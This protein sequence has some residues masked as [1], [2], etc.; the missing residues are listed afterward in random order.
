MSEAAPVEAP[1]VGLRRRLAERLFGFDYFIS[2]RRTSSTRYAKALRAAL[3]DR[4]LSAFLDAAGDGFVPGMPLARETARAVR[5]STAMVL[6]VQSDTFESEYIIDEIR[7]FHRAGKLLV[8]IDLDGT[9]A[10]LRNDPEARQEVT[11]DEETRGLLEATC[12]SPIAI[13]EEDRAQEPSQD[14]VDKLAGGLGTLTRAVLR[15]RF[16]LATALLVVLLASAAM[17]GWTQERA[18]RKQ[19]LRRLAEVEWRAAILAREDTD[20]I[21]A[22]HHFLASATASAEAG[23]DDRVSDAQLAASLEL[24]AFDRAWVHGGV[25]DG[26]AFAPEAKRFVAWSREG[27]LR[28]WSTEQAQPLWSAAESTPIDDVLWLAQ[29]RHFLSHSGHGIVARWAPAESNQPTWRYEHDNPIDGFGYHQDTG[30]AL[31]WSGDGYVFLLN[32]TSGESLQTWRHGSSVISG[33]FDSSGSR[34][35]TASSDETVCMWSTA[36]TEPKWCQTFDSGARGAV[37]SPDESSVLSWTIAGAVHLL[38]ATDGASAWQRR[39]NDAVIG[40]RFVD[41]ETVLTWS[42]DGICT[43]RAVRDGEEI[44]QLEQPGNLDGCDL[45]PSKDRALTWAGWAGDRTARLWTR[46]SST[47]SAW[48]AVTFSHESDVHDAWI[49]ASGDVLSRTAEGQLLIWSAGEIEPTWMQHHRGLGGVAPDPSGGVL[50]WGDNGIIRRWTPERSAPTS[51]PVA[52]GRAELSTDGSSV[53]SATSDAVVRYRVADAEILDRF[54]HRCGLLGWRLLPTGNVLSWCD[55]GQLFVWISSQEEPRRLDGEDDLLAVTLLAE[56]RT[57]LAW[58]E[59]GEHRLWSLVDGESIA[60]LTHWRADEV[61]YDEMTGR[62]I[63][64]GGHDQTARVW[65]ASSGTPLAAYEHDNWIQWAAFGDNDTLVTL[66][67]LEVRLIPAE[68]CDGCEVVDRRL[69]HD[70]ELEGAELSADGRRVITWTDKEVLLWDVGSGQLLHENGYEDEDP[71]GLRGAV[72]NADGSM[73][74]SWT[75][76]GLRSWTP[77]RPHEISD[78]PASGTAAVRFDR[79]ADRFW[80]WSHSGVIRLWS[81]GRTEHLLELAGTDSVGALELSPEG[82]ALLAWDH[83]TAPRW[84]SI[85][86]SQELDPHREMVALAAR[87]GVGFG[88][89]GR[90]ET[91]PFT[92]WLE[93]VAR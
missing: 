4:R 36:D 77:Q 58:H 63:T 55:D 80:S 17:V 71:V 29:G 88:E 31:A 42:E 92:E 85:A 69:N 40:G 6:L 61:A 49:Q 50:S 5:S 45:A 41:A 48:E 15:A 21:R 90:V 76:A 84:W 18:A 73:V 53:L 1:R 16:I 19:S 3:I 39:H 2:Y 83:E 13:E 8:P 24:R 22:A 74:V 43:L 10:R 9:L 51:A 14:V 11:D 66:S 70:G 37:W 38:G 86:A 65:D 93:L 72:V 78:H 68:V 52:I 47:P 82:A 26:I 33:A 56:G 30:R 35:V 75:A 23:D 46:S 54:E 34:V 44:W 25:V 81:H 87:S 62:L 79:N 57:A 67:G 64:W 7:R 59:G 28:L 27:L 89:T 12:L 91:M 20:S 60:T 32:A